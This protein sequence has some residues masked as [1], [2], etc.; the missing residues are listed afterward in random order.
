MRKSGSRFQ[1][2][3]VLSYGA[4][5]VPLSR[6][7]SVR[8]LPFIERLETIRKALKDLFL[9]PYD[10]SKCFLENIFGDYYAFLLSSFSNNEG[11][12]IVDF[13][14]WDERGSWH[15]LNRTFEVSGPNS[16]FPPDLLD[17][18]IALTNKHS[19]GISFCSGCGKEMKIVDCAGRFY[20]SHFCTKCWEGK[21]RKIEASENYD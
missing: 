15:I 17:E 16:V 19:E 6:L 12:V 1:D 8:V 18:I 7:Y 3:P 13:T 4:T 11:K 9:Y 20:A 14:V 10:N 21:W 5:I 2:F